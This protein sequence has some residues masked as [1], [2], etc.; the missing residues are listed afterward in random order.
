MDFERSGRTWGQ[1]DPTGLQGQNRRGCNMVLE[2]AHAP[3]SNERRQKSTAVL[4]RHQSPRRTIVVHRL[5]ISPPIRHVQLAITHHFRRR[6]ATLV[7]QMVGFSVLFLCFG[8]Q[9]PQK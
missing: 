8:I 3:W 7:V 1:P 6:P 4:P 2:D 9:L 5:R